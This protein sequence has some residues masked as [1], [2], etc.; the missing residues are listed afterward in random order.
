M[1][2][3]HWLRHLVHI[4]AQSILAHFNDMLTLFDCKNIHAIIVFESCFKSTGSGCTGGGVAIYVRS[5]IFF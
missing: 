2:N 3:P 5:H 1:L 4:N